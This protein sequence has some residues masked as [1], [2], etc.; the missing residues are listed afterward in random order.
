MAFADRFI[1]H[2][3]LATDQIQESSQDPTV[4]MLS[5]AAKYYPSLAIVT[6]AAD[7]D[8][9][10]ALLDII[11]TVKLEHDV[12]KGGW[13]MSAFG[14]SGH[15]LVDALDVMEADVWSIAAKVLSTSR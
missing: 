1:A 11:T 14:E 9:E 3:E 8:P 2:I 12:W 6:S 7:P 10:V 15:Y 13:A 5:Q 4:R